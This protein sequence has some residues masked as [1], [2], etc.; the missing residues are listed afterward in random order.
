MISGKYDISS[1]LCH[2]PRILHL[3]PTFMEQDKGWWILCLLRHF[4]WLIV[5]CVLFFFPFSPNIP[6]RLWIIAQD[7]FPTKWSS[8]H[9]RLKTIKTSKKGGILNQFIHW[10]CG[11]ALYVNGKNNLLP[12]KWHER[13]KGAIFFILSPSNKW[14]FIF[15]VS[16]QWGFG[17]CKLFSAWI[18]ISTCLGP[19]QHPSRLAVYL[20]AGSGSC[21]SVPIVMVTYEEHWRSGHA[22]QAYWE[23]FFALPWRL[24][25]TETIL[26]Y[27][28][29]TYRKRNK[30]RP[31]LGL[32]PV[33][34]S[35]WVSE[36]FWWI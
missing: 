36:L 5:C 24:S 2:F 32:C 25:K 10:V 19:Y 9:A 33:A 3:K 26:E 17:A 35:V 21:L 12:A 15:L 20:A 23:I 13:A 16:G 34:R 6:F 27:S 8:W 29:I 7:N 22:W 14:S 30:K 18:Q 11:P 1:R 28:W 31:L 4:Y